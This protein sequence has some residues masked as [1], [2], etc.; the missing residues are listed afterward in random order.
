MNKIIKLFFVAVLISS[1]P[2]CPIYASEEN[3]I[4]YEEINEDDSITVYNTAEGVYRVLCN[5]NSAIIYDDNGQIAGALSYEL[6]ET[7]YVRGIKHLYTGEIMQQNEM[8]R[9]YDVWYTYNSLGIVQITIDVFPATVSA[10]ASLINSI[11]HEN[12]IWTLFATAQDLSELI[13]TIVSNLD[14][15]SVRAEEAFNVYCNILKRE[16]MVYSSTYGGPTYRWTAS[17]WVYAGVPDACRILADT[18][19]Y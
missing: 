15:F 17:P 8:Q 12:N 7:G 1:I 11:M 4:V 16:R 14:H 13:Y 3:A 2:L 5:N 9:G 19:P 10:L 6:A 18:Y